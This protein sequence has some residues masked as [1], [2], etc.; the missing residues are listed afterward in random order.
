VYVIA[1]SQRSGDYQTRYLRCPKCG[2][3]DKQTLLAVEVRRRKLF[4]NASS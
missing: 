3:T 4:T 2:A 1:S